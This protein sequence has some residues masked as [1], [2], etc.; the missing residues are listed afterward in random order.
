VIDHFCGLIWGGLRPKPSLGPRADN[1]IIPFDLT[2]LLCP[3][4]MLAAG[5][6]S[7]FT[8]NGVGCWGGS[9]VESLQSHSI[10][11]MSY[12]PICFPSQGT[13]V[14]IPRG[15]LM[16]NR[17]SP[18]SVVSLQLTLFS[19]L[20]VFLSRIFSLPISNFRGQPERTLKPRNVFNINTYHKI[21]TTNHGKTIEWNRKYIEKYMKII[22]KIVI[23]QY[24]ARHTTTRSILPRDLSRRS[25]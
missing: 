7:S 18:V 12:L 3:G 14:Q 21:W 22:I 8:T 4:F 2:Q 10:L 1:L 11:T 25:V 16:W 9:P 5:L 13:Q 19:L 23:F 20:I 24:S 17:D 15:V 6:P